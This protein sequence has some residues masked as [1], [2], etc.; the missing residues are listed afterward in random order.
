ME[1]VPTGRP[2]PID[3][4]VGLLSKWAP[5]SLDELRRKYPEQE[6]LLQ[7]GFICGDT[8]AEM[9]VRIEVCLLGLSA[10]AEKSRATVEALKKKL[11]IAN[12]VQFGGQLVTMIG[13]ASIFTV[14]AVDV[15]NLAR[16]VER[17]SKIGSAS[18]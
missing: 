1:N 2:V 6:E 4:L 10:A 8:P 7:P 12:K 18:R 5:S 17:V 16:Y 9:A 13:G 15:P 3:E 11:A 14:M